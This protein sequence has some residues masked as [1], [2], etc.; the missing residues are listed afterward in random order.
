MTQYNVHAIL[1]VLIHEIMGSVPVNKMEEQSLWYFIKQ[2]AWLAR[3]SNSADV[4]F[5]VSRY[6]PEIY[7]NLTK[8]GP[9]LK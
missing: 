9:L 3:S 8:H 6:W 7:S 1:S 5:F 4:K 2:I